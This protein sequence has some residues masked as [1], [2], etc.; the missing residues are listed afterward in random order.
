MEIIFGFEDW[1]LK[2]VGMQ[3]LTEQFI[4]SVR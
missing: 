4:C 3:I 1:M 2:M